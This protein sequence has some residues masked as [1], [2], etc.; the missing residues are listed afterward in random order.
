MTRSVSGPPVKL[1]GFSCVGLTCFHRLQRASNSRVGSY[2]SL[3]LN[4]GFPVSRAYVR[5]RSTPAPQVDNLCHVPEVP[6]R[7]VHA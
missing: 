3:A 1:S 7:C 2:L 4:F 6:R 5:P